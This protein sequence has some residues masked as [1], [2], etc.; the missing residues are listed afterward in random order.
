MKTH[1]LTRF[2]HSGHTC[3][4]MCL[5]CFHSTLLA[6]QWGSAAFTLVTPFAGANNPASYH[7]LPF[8]LEQW[9]GLSCRYQQVYSASEFSA[10]G[11]QRAYIDWIAFRSDST[12][13]RG[14]SANLP[15]VEILMGI[16]Q[17]N[18]DGLGTTFAENPDGGMTTVYSQGPLMFGAS[19]RGSLA[20]I[21]LQ[22]PFLFDPNAGNLLLE[23][24]NYERIPPPY[25][26][27][28]VAGPLDAWEITG[29]AVSRVYAYDVNAANGVADTLGLT[30]YFVVTPV[31]KL[32]IA[33]VS[34]N[35]VFR[36][37][38]APIEF[39][40]QQSAALGL[41]T[42]WQPAG[43]IVTTNRATNGNYD[44]EVTLPVDRKS[45]AR[46]FRLVSQPSS[47]GA[48]GPQPNNE[49]SALPNQEP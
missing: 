13:G 37:S 20:S 4:L 41:S 27:V 29:D 32:A 1:W 34:S 43:G 31:P 3:L 23:V 44:I 12:F 30:T 17:R 16:T 9:G 46:F 33:L 2:S 5:L 49:P 47:P 15:S 22:T 6:S 36:W 18:P 10:L 11:G 7:L 19:D 40:L 25:Q 24:R 14:F 26:P 45:P 28:F 38:L 8:G 21:I 48:A 39:T 35:L 42:S